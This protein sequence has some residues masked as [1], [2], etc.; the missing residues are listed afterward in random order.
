MTPNERRRPKLLDASRRKRIATGSGT[1][2]QDVNQLMKQFQQ[3]QHLMKKFSQQ[4]M[5][6]IK[7]LFR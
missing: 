5:P 3:M 7:G 4:K 2:V 1:S 6:D